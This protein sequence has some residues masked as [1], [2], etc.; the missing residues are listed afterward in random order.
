MNVISFH[1]PVKPYLPQVAFH[2][3][4]A[5]LGGQ[6][7][8]PFNGH[9]IDINKCMRG[10]YVAG[11]I[12]NGHRVIHRGTLADCIDRALVHY[13]AKDNHGVSLKIEL[14]TDGNCKVMDSSADDIKLCED[15]GRLTAGILPG[16][17]AADW[18]TWKHD[19]AVRCVYDAV[20]PNANRR[21]L[22]FDAALIEKYHGKVAYGG[23]LI[24]K[25]GTKYNGR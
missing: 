7:I 11:Y 13:D 25:Y 3:C 14:F 20:H 19:V 16:P 8:Q 1:A 9:R 4:Q 2:L 10:H 22:I 5:A 21:E 24:D 23:A 12:F 17:R 18:W 15:H 6:S